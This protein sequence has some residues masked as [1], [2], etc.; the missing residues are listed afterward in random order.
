MLAVSFVGLE[1]VDD[2]AYA[3]FSPFFNLFPAQEQRLTRASAIAEAQRWYLCT[4]FRD[5][6]ELL[7]VFLDQG[8]LLC[9]LFPSAAQGK[10]QS[11][12]YNRIFGTEIR[13]FHRLGLPDKL[14]K[15]QRHFG[16][17]S[18]LEAH[19]L[20]INTV[21]N[22][23]VH[24]LGIVTDRDVDANGELVLL[25]RTSDLVAQNPDGTQELSI[26]DNPEIQIVPGWTVIYRVI[27]KKKVFR[28]AER[29]DLSYR[30]ITDTFLSLMNFTTTL[31]VS[32][33]GYGKQVGVRMP[34]PQVDNTQLS[35]P[36]PF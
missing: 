26:L 29:I 2:S 5:A 6:I 24:R 12:D 22:C 20:S 16:V 32:I 10:I 13:Q 23:L 11:D 19:V 9:A 1:K 25:W 33:E 36:H 28:K 18:E 4:A 30:E 21:R 17:A 31:A 3:S 15:L 35:I 14:K 7:N 34:N 8:R 27:D